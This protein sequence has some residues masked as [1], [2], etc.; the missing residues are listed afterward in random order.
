MTL[1]TPRF[2]FI[3]SPYISNGLLAILQL[4]NLMQCKSFAE[5]LPVFGSIR[6]SLY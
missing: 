6:F 3:P 5:S 4:Y 2:L 1:S